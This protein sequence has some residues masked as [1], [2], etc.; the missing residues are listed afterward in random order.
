MVDTK[1][2]IISVAAR[3]LEE[4]GLMMVEP[5][6]ASIEVLR[7]DEP[8][9]LTTIEFRGVVRGRYDIIAQR[10]FAS[11]LAQNVLGSEIEI[12]DG[13]IEDALKE[14]ANVLCGNM[15]TECYGADVVFE[16]TPPAVAVC[17]RESLQGIETERTIAFL[18]DDTPVLFTF[19]LIVE[20]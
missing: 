20:E 18:A 15:L 11:T 4:W 1:E 6:E 8:V 3:I 19:A 10:Q 12:D 14:L 16:L 2:A 9:Y 17:S 13:V 5:C 7:T